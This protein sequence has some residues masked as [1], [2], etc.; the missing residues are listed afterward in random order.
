MLGNFLIFFGFMAKFFI[1]L[2]SLC[3]KIS[4]NFETL[5]VKRWLIILLAKAEPRLKK[6]KANILRKYI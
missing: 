3:P 5:R 6:N 4:I 1:K 2:F